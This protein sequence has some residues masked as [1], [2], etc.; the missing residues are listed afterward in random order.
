MSEET[1]I[2]NDPTKQAEKETT[3]QN[4]FGY[5]QLQVFQQSVNRKA[6]RAGFLTNLIKN[7][8]KITSINTNLTAAAI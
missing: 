4:Y 2:L 5:D 1:E 3:I 6:S 8:V 7:A